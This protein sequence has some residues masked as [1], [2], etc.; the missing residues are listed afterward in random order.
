[1]P[2]PSPTLETNRLILRP[3]LAEDFEPWAAFAADPE[4]SRYLGGPQGREGAWRQ[5]C[6]VTGAWT[7]RGFS[8]FS[9]IEK[10]TGAWIGRLG[11]WQPEGWPGTEVGWG[12]ARAAWGKGYATEGAAAAIDWAFDTFGWTE[13]IHCIDAENVGSHAVAQRLGSRMLREVTLPPPLA[14]PVQVWGQSREAWKARRR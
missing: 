1:V 11:P 9:V 3:P 5:M 12:L 10:S 8:M 2:K 7:V 4:A 13:V 14:W 6:V